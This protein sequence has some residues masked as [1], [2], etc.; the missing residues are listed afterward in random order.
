ME[1]YVGELEAVVD[2]LGIGR[3]ILLGHSMGALHAT[4]YAARHPGAALALVHVDIEPCPPS[5]NKK[6]LTGLYRDLP[7]S[8]PTVEDYVDRRMENSA[9]AD[10]GRLLYLA[11]NH[12]RNENGRWVCLH[13]REVYA[14]FDPDYD[15]RPRLPDIACPVLV[16]RGEDSLV[17]PREAMEEMRRRLKRGAA[18]EVPRA[19]HPVHTDN[20]EGFREAVFR[21]L[22]DGGF[23]IR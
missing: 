10:R 8:Y 17:L 23:L 5:W 2:R 3:M 12:L 21:F 1:D 19:A 22:E 4:C 16:V 7:D 13:D 15:L 18:A 11:R 20:P 14:H 9:Y 6:Y